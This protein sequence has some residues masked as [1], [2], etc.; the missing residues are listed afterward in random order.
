MGPWRGVPRGRYIKDGKGRYKK[1]GRYPDDDF[2]KKK[3]TN[4]LIPCKFQGPDGPSCDKLPYR[5]GYCKRHGPDVVFICEMCDT[6]IK[7]KGLTKHICYDCSAK[8]GTQCKYCGSLTL[9]FDTYVC[10]NHRRLCSVPGCNTRA[11]KCRGKLFPDIFCLKH[12]DNTCA[13]VDTINCPNQVAEG[14]DKCT[15]HGGQRVRGNIVKSTKTSCG[16]MIKKKCN[17]QK[18]HIRDGYE[19]RVIDTTMCKKH[20]GYVTCYIGDCQN[21]ASEGFS[22]KCTI[23]GGRS[24]TSCEGPIYIDGNLCNDCK[25]K[26]KLERQKRQRDEK[27]KMT[28]EP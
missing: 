1:K 13:H 6:A 2:D 28:A 7:V 26:Q 14:N 15:K 5:N 27:K 19:T 8:L 17:N 21:M 3:L 11:R 4:S 25:Y 12:L 9:D 10:K 24:C 22:G 18:P 16:E 23:H 20:G